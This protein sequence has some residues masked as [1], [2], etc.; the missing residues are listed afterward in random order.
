MH[1]LEPQERRNWLKR[2]PVLATAST[3]FAIAVASLFGRPITIGDLSIGPLIAGPLVVWTKNN[4]ITTSQRGVTDGVRL[5]DAATGTEGASDLTVYFFSDWRTATGN[6]AN[7]F[8]DGGKWTVEG[9][10]TFG[11][12]GIS[13]VRV[14]ATDSRDYPTT[15]YLRQ[16]NQS[17]GAGQVNEWAE[18]GFDAADNIIPTSAVDAAGDTLGLRFYVNFRVPNTFT[19]DCDFHGVYFTTAVNGGSGWPPG[20]MGLQWYPSCDIGTPANQ[21]TATITGYSGSSPDHYACEVGGN[22]VFLDLNTTYRFETLW[23]RTGTNTYTL[24]KRIYNQAGTLLCDTNN[25]TSDWFG[26][27]GTNLSSVTFN[28]SSFGGAGS[29]AM[30]GFKI[31]VNG[32]A[33]MTAGSIY[34]EWAAVAI[35]NSW[36]GAY[37]ISGVEN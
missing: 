21:W 2:G 24:R 6:S 16:N 28:T 22:D 11:A 25:F 29:G 19:A 34:A 27:P 17:G 14:T 13:A 33:T 18:L 15:N 36:C 30:R 10:G 23:I 26:P 3:A 32:G 12:G 37:P 9:N 8:S 31:G 20:A 1:D 7:A 35:C 4:N 5:G